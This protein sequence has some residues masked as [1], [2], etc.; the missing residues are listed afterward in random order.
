MVTRAH[1][2]A[3]SPCWVDLWTSDVGGSRAFYGELLGWESGEPDPEFGGYFIFTRQGVDI[4]G[5]MGDMG[6]GMEANDTWKVYLATDDINATTEA[7]EA[8]GAEILAPAMPVGELGI[9]TVLVDPT[10]A[11]LGAW[12]EGTFP[13]FTVLDEH[14]APG[15]FELHTRQ[16]ATALDFY[17]TVFHWETASVGDSDAL[18]YATMQ[19]PVSK[20][21][22]AG[23]LDASGFLPEGTPPYWALYWEVDDADAAVTVVESLGGSVVRAVEDTPY[24]RI[25]TVADPAGAIFRLRTGPR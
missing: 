15:W 4:A 20:E 3:G 22:L 7:A 17:R 25:A 19:D 18:R 16:Y 1:A 9:Q 23:I 14:G 12:E 11:N 24:G 5:C 13:G 8:A 6:E 10:G 21:P 2:P